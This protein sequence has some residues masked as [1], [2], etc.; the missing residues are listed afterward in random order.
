MKPTHLLGLLTVLLV[1]LAGCGFIDPSVA[2]TVTLSPTTLSFSR[3]LET[4]Q[5]TATVLDQNGAT[6]SN[7]FLTWSSSSSLAYVSSTGLVTAVAEAEGT[8]TI[9]ATSGSA[10]GE[11]SFTV[12]ATPQIAFVRDSEI[13]VM[14]VDGSNQVNLTNNAADDGGPTWSPNGYGIAFNSNRDGNDEIYM[15]EANGS[16]VV[17]LTNNIDRDVSPA[18]S[19][20]LRQIAFQSFRDGNPEIYLMIMDG[21]N[22]PSYLPYTEEGPSPGVRV[23]ERTNLTNDPLSDGSPAWSPSFFELAFHSTRDGNSEIYVM[24]VVGFPNVSNVVRLTNNGAI[25]EDP[26]PSPDG[27]QIAFRS[28][29]DGNDEIYVM[30]ADGSNVVRLTNNAVFDGSP[31]WSPDRCC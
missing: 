14:A 23:F 22:L 4:Q 8:A 11:A 6:I 13:Y 9:W 2:T 16:N 25:D 30:D 7:A 18:W 1:N 5:L 19:G 28:S 21:D 17:R 15:M 3:F 27:S 26:A 24:D 31:A 12:L 29:R 20:N 10:I